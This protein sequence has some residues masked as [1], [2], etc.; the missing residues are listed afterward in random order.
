MFNS[1]VNLST[2]ASGRLML[3]SLNTFNYMRIHPKATQLEL[4]HWFY[5]KFNKQ[6]NQSR[7]MGSRNVESYTVLIGE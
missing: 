6:I 2:C 5:T 4:S 3:Q 7:A 1:R